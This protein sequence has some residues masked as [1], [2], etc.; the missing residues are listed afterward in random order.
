MARDEVRNQRH[1]AMLKRRETLKLAALAGGGVLF[2]R[3]LG[4]CAETEPAAPAAAL[5]ALDAVRSP[6]FLGGLT[7]SLRE[8]LRYE[9]TVCGRLP[10]ALRGTL[11][12]NGPGLFERA[13]VRKRTLLDGDG[14][15]TAYRLE[16]GRVEFLNRHVRT[17]KF[18]AEEAAGRYLLDSWT[19][20]VQTPPTP[21]S[22]QAG[23]TAWPWS[24][25]LYAFDEGNPPWELDPHNLRTIAQASFGLAR[26]QA[27]LFAHGKQ[28]AESGQFTLFGIQYS[29]LHY[30][31]LVLDTA[32]RV[33]AQRTF[34][35]TEFGPPGYMH[36]WFVNSPC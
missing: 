17:P 30:N 28:L 18:E 4:A 21:G 20:P 27:S 7:T 13:G 29:N 8:E 36:D 16:R 9:A 10:R 26:E 32:H 2:S 22:D 6:L 19:T 31:Y 15:I 33:V 12:K 24:G 3:G 25:R 1:P 23:V 34:P 5:D 35:V 14:M 11:Y